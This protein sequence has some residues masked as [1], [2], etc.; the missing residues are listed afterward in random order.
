[1]LELLNEWSVKRPNGRGTRVRC[2][3]KCECGNV[4]EYI[5]ENIVRG[6]TT[7]CK[8]CSN[9]SRSEKHTK[10]GHNMSHSKGS[11]TKSYYTWQA[12]KRRCL[13]DYD[14]KSEYYKGKGITI[15]DEWIGSFESFLSDMGEPPT[16]LHSIDRID[17]SKGYSKENCRW[18]TQLQQANNKSNNVKITVNATTK[19]LCQWVQISGIKRKTITSRIKR[20]WSE[21]DAIM[22]DIGKKPNQC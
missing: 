10:H 22:T 4:S 11:C 20:G 5:K 13:T 15:C 16:K 3:A 2:H 18:A 12:M 21:Y 9:K 6:N 8:D 14:S 7:R 1:M 19:N 17:N